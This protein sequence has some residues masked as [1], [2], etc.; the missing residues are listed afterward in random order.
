MNILY[1][2]IN[3]VTGKSGLVLRKTGTCIRDLG[4]SAACGNNIV[5]VSS[6][7]SSRYEARACVRGIEANG[8]TGWIWTR[9]IHS[10]KS[11]PRGSSTEYDTCTNNVI[12][13]TNKINRN[14][15]IVS[16]LLECK[17]YSNQM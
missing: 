11:E 7:C 12:I 8:V 2:K 15:F 1:L 17:L 6:V 5:N 3:P 14:N 9:G 4:K 10:D 16:T 13:S